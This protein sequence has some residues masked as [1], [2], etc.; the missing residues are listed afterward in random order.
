MQRKIATLHPIYSCLF[1]APSGTVSTNVYQAKDNMVHIEILLPPIL[2]WLLHYN[3]WD[4][5]KW[6][7]VILGVGAIPGGLV[8]LALHHDR[9]K[10][11]QAG[12]DD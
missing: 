9:E 1:W 12:N 4:A 2:E 11:R 6:L 8:A 3:I 10:L 5:L 7:F